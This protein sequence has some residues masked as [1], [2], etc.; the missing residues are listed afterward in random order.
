M[1]TV[2][3]FLPHVFDMLWWL[4]PNVDKKNSQYNYVNWHQNQNK[5]QQCLPTFSLKH[6]HTFIAIIFH[7]A[8]ATARFVNVRF[9][10]IG[11]LKRNAQKYSPFML[12]GWCSC[13]LCVYKFSARHSHFHE[14]H[15]KKMCCK[16]IH[17]PRRAMP[18]LMLM[19]MLEEREKDSKQCFNLLMISLTLRSTFEQLKYI[20][21][22]SVMCAMQKSNFIRA[23][24]S[25]GSRKL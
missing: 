3:K 22:I 19:S 10:K 13:L 25:L 24:R 21:W 9:L 17:L 15:I 8:I 18:M 20:L 2:G 11:F 4:P 7:C 6:K 1:D 16:F 23:K 5:H 14:T 12:L